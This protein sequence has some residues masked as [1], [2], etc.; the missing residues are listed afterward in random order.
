MATETKRPIFATKEVVIKGQTTT[1]V[2][3]DNDMHFSSD[4]RCCIC[5]LRVRGKHSYSVHLS[6]NGYLLPVDQFENDY[7]VTQGFF[8][9]GSECRKQLPTTHS[10]KTEW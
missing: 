5:N 6:V 2:E 1:V 4:D 7:D 10:I 9:V 3:W 8:S